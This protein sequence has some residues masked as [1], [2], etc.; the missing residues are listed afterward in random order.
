[1]Y[2]SCIIIL[3]YGATLLHR[4]A[5]KGSKRCLQHLVEK[6]NKSVSIED[7]VSMLKTGQHI[8]LF[9]HLLSMLCFIQRG[10]Q[11]LHYAAYNGQ[12]DAVEFLL[13]RQAD[14]NA[15]NEVRIVWQRNEM[16]HYNFVPLY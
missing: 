13:A 5:G 11:P 6:D 7:K 9:N 15:K 2:N 12:A 1:M 14:I 3:Q 10:C 8:A 4:A 16:Y